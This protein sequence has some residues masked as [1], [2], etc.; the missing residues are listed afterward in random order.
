MNRHTSET[1]KSAWAG[2][3]VAGFI[4]NVFGGNVDANYGGRADQK[5]KQETDRQQNVDSLD[6]C[7]VGDR[8]KS[9]AEGFIIVTLVKIDVKEGAMEVNKTMIPIPS[10]V[11]IFLF[12]LLSG[13]YVCINVGIRNLTGTSSVS[14]YKSTKDFMDL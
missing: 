2:V 10:A 5:L 6:I 14:D 9:K 3:G 13:I 11:A 8:G 12:L 7:Y 4:S 1:H